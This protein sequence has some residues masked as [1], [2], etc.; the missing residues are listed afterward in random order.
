MFRKWFAV[1]GVPALAAV[2]LLV[3]VE[4]ASARPWFGGGWRGGYYGYYGPGY[5]SYGY[6]AYYSYG[7]S[8]PNYYGWYGTPYYSSGYSTYSP[9][10]YYSYPTYSYTP[11]YAYGSTSSSY[12]SFYPTEGE[13]PRDANVA[14]LDVRV[15]ADAQVWIDGSKTTQTGTERRFE[16]PT[17]TPGK[18]YSYDVRARWMG[19]EGEVTRTKHVTFHAGDRV[20]VDFMKEGR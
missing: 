18:T 15:P 14:M 9:G 7:Y 4:T 6:P 2:A 13:E 20:S 17:L 1:L 3:A 8:Y 11:Q 5:Y 12:Q 10:Y 16:S 19:D